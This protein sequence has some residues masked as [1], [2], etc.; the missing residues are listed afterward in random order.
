MCELFAMSTRLPSAITLSLEEFSRHGGQTGPHKEGWGIAWYEHGDLHLLKEATSASNSKTM[1]FIKDNPFHSAL[2]L[3]HI[4]KATQGDVAS[5]NCQPSMREL[6]GVWHSFAHNGN[7][8]GLQEDPRFNASN[9]QTIGETDSEYAFCALMDRMQTLWR[10]GQRPTYEARRDV[11]TAFAADLRDTGPANFFYS[12]GEVL[13]AHAHQRHHADGT[14]RAPGLWL[15]T[16]HCAE[17]GVFE[18]SGLHVEAR[19][20]EQDVVLLASVPLSQEDWRPLDEGEVIS[21]RLGR[22]L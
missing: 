13:F 15:L 17:G 14:I 2:V 19:G 8:K 20:A 5:R 1:Q 6:G 9:Y 22:T 7:L 21:V 11:V 10:F 4:R 18:G 3:C 16:R 12:D